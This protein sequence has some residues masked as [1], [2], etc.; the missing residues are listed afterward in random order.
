M[1]CWCFNKMLIL[2]YYLIFFLLMQNFPEDNTSS[3]S[4]SLMLCKYSFKLTEMQRI[5]KILLNVK[6]DSFK[7]NSSRNLYFVSSSPNAPFYATRMFHLDSNLI[8]HTTLHCY[9]WMI[10]YVSDTRKFTEI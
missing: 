10:K 8:T 6:F 5:L 4:C 3:I 7:S 9:D 1:C 2:I